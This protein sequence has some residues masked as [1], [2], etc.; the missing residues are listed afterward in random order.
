[1][2]LDCFLLLM[3]SVGIVVALGYRTWSTP[4]EEST[5]VPDIAHR[6]MRR[7]I[8]GVGMPKVSKYCG[9]MKAAQ[10]NAAA[11]QHALM[12]ERTLSAARAVLV[13][14]KPPDAV[15][16]E[17]GMSR[18]RLNGI[19]AELA[20]SAIPD[21]WVSAQVCLPKALMQKVRAME[22]KERDRLKK[23]EQMT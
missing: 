12:H 15:A 8:K 3:C 16:T 22:A 13:E 1:M 20:S 2:I 21:G 9:L 18:Q 11:S 7:V 10:F 14:G 5:A 17:S 19:L 6:I 23:Q 4:G